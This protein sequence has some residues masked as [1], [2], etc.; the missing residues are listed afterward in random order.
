MLRLAAFLS[1][2]SYI[3]TLPP[4]KWDTIQTYIHC[5]N[6]TGEWNSEALAV[7]ATQPFVVFEKNHKLM[8]APANTSAETKIAESCRLVKTVNPA[9]DCYIYTESDWARTWY[10]RFCPLLLF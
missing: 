5:A 3:N 10:W 8:A 1:V 2:V 6:Y 7:L 4:W 9:T